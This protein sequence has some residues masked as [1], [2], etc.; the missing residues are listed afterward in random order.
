MYWAWASA[1]STLTF[2][3]GCTTR[4]RSSLQV[5]RCIITLYKWI[6]YHSFNISII[7]YLI[8]FYIWI[9]LSL[10]S[11]KILL[12]LGQPEV[13]LYRAT[14]LAELCQGER[15]QA[16]HPLWSHG[17]L[18]SGFCDQVMTTLTYLSPDLYVKYLTRCISRFWKYFWVTFFFMQVAITEDWS[19]RGDIFSQSQLDGQD[20]VLHQVPGSFGRQEIHR[21]I[22]DQGVTCIL[23][24]IWIA[25]CLNLKLLLSI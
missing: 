15:D 24:M 17:S 7:H 9:F 1:I 18:G 13:V 10:F 8:I 2:L 19:V 21:L 20:A 5:F 23:W 4:P 11:T 6:N 16:P 22:R 3:N 25:N 12:F 14:K